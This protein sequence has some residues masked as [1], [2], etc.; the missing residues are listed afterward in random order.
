MIIV[1]N[2][3]SSTIKYKVFEYKTL[4]ELY[5]KK[6]ENIKNKEKVV[7]KVLKKWKNPKLI[8]HRVVHG[9]E[10]FTDPTLVN[11]KVIKQLKTLNTLAPL[12]NPH[13]L[14]IIEL[15]KKELP[16]TKQVAVFDTGFYKTLPEKSFLYALPYSLYKKHGIRKYGFHGISHQYLASQIKAKKLIT[17]H[18]GNGSSITAIKNGKAIETTMGFTP[19]EGLPMGTR[20][21]SIDPAIPLHLIKQLKLSPKKVEEI[22]NKESGFKGLS[23]KTSDVRVLHKLYKNKDPRAILTLEKFAYECAKVI[24]AYYIVLGGLD[25]LAFTGGIGE[26]APYI[27]NLIKKHLKHLPKFDIMVFQANE[28]LQIA[29]LAKKIK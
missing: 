11:Q 9:G 20:C 17:C 1:F 16:K 12:H 5:S 7:K 15:C 8:A 3:G 29:K 6:I 22:L 26:N 21:G 18:L 10:K 2:A 27:R 4:K 13:N 25:T 24:G 28:E 19:L 14:E 23:G